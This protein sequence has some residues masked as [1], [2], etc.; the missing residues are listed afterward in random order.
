M[1]REPNDNQKW[2]RPVRWDDEPERPGSIWDL[3]HLIIDAVHLLVGLVQD[4]ARGIGQAAKKAGR[5]LTAFWNGIPLLGAMAGGGELVTGWQAHGL[6]SL[7]LGIS[8]TLGGPAIRKL[9][10]LLGSESERQRRRVQRATAEGRSDFPTRRREEEIAIAR[11]GRRLAPE[12]DL[13][14]LATSEE[15][16]EDVVA[17]LRR[18]DYEPVIV[19]VREQRTCLKVVLSLGAEEPA[20]E[21]GVSWPRNSIYGHEDGYRPIMASLHLH[22]A[23]VRF[24]TGARSWDL[25]LAS[26]GVISDEATLILCKSVRMLL[27]AALAQQHQKTLDTNEER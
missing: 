8:L 15:A 21:D 19:L 18:M 23:R 26:G 20:L 16:L 12:T 13:P 6:L 7:R 22:H 14:A 25:I 27:T 4:L 24:Q 10:K 2:G 1:P 9:I 17:E 11:L 5:T 3:M